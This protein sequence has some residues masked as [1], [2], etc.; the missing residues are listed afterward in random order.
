MFL[1]PLRLTKHPYGV[2]PDPVRVGR[3]DSHTGASEV[4]E[5]TLDVLDL[6]DLTFGDNQDPGPLSARSAAPGDFW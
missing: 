2:G 6:G 1:H 5:E 3:P 4:L